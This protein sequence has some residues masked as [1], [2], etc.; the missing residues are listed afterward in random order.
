MV[1]QTNEQAL[2]ASIE[3]ALT[4]QSQE[5]VKP[6]VARVQVSILGIMD[7]S[8]DPRQILMPSMLWM[9]IGFGNFYRIARLKN[10]KEFKK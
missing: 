10:W 8:E 4:G 3:K 1:S 7:L 2:E 6:G 5:E 9:S